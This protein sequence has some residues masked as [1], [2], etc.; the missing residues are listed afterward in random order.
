MD[1]PR[2]ARP[3]PFLLASLAAL[4]CLLGTYAF[5]V[6]TAVG[7]HI[8]ESALLEA[9]AMFGARARNGLQFLDFMPVLSVLPAAAA[10]GF[11][12]IARRRWAATFIALTAAATANGAAY[13]LKHYVLDR[14]DLGFNAFAVNTMPSGHATLTA[15]S[16]AAIFLVASPAWRPP[17]AF[18]GAT[19]AVFSGIFTIVNQW[20]LPADVVASFLLVGAVAAPAAWLTLRAESSS[21]HGGSGRASGSGPRWSSLSLRVAVGAAAVA[22]VAMVLVAPLPADQRRVG[23]AASFFWAGAASIAM[24]GYLG[25]AAASWLVSRGSPKPRGTVGEP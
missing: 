11:A 6:R 24:A 5:F 3:G 13:V 14:P 9:A 19:Y 15:S 10:L 17:A 12:A 8:D 2:P 16:A 7:Q 25:S 21:P 22:A 20:H 23:S 1:A 18:A 4:A